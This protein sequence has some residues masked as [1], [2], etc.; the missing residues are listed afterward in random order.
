M[1]VDASLQRD[2]RSLLQERNSLKASIRRISAQIDSDAPSTLLSIKSAAE[3]SPNGKRKFKDSMEVDVEEPEK[4]PKLGS[5]VEH[6]EAQRRLVRSSLLGYLQRAKDALTKEQEKENVIKHQEK[7]Q[8]IASKLADQEREKLEKIS[9]E[10]R[11]KLLAE[12]E[13]LRVVESNLSEKHNELVVVV[14][15]HLDNN[16]MQKSSLT[17]HYEYMSNFIATKTQPT[18]FWLP[19][20]FNTELESLREC[21]RQFIAQKVAAIASTDYGTMKRDTSNGD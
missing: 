19:R 17:R 10:L 11:N 15:C 9:A 3:S 21:T 7:E 18:I 6:V 14:W 5:A 20:N 12:E 16:I 4:R 13:R 1:T 2:I 8:L